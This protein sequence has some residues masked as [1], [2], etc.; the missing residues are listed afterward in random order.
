MSKVNARGMAESI[1]TISAFS[2]VMVMVAAVAF[3]IYMA[4]SMLS[5]WPHNLIWIAPAVVV[6]VVYFSRLKKMIN[7]DYSQNA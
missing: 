5:T 3:K 7:D 2:A 4:L 1:F 6:G